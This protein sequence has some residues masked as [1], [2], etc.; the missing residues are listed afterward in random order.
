VTNET[1]NAM[2]NWQ[3]GFVQ[4]GAYKLHY[5]RAGQGVPLLLV[6][7][8]TDNAACWLAFAEPLTHHYDVVMYD[9]RGHGLSDQPA[10]HYAP[11]DLAADM[12]NV[13]IALNL[14][15]PIVIGH[16]MGAMATLAAATTYSELMRA[17]VLE[18]PPLEM[19]NPQVDADVAAANDAGFYAW[20]DEMKTLSL[21]QLIV[22][23]A[24]DNP[25]W[26]AAE[27]RPWAYAKLQVGARL[28]FNETD[29][30]VAWQT[31]MAALTMP[32]L[33]VVGD[34]ASRV[35][36]TAQEAALARQLSPWVE[37][38]LIRNVGH[39]IRREA[40]AAYA[41]LVGDFLKRTQE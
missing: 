23:G 4:S 15:R 22:R 29:R 16:S 38:G 8:R 2:T 10:A 32:T 19:L 17:I 1:G 30:F 41:A 5:Q 36:V 3:T 21:E 33:L 25:T 18:D 20:I 27:L 13:I 6:H 26:Q 35:L 11:H 37:I 39:C 34:P 28:P 9:A 40:P 12:R 24:D 14:V 31:M 7:G